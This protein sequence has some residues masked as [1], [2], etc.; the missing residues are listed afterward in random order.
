MPGL[1]E[2]LRRERERQGL[3]VSAIAA[4]TRIPAR[5]IEAIE[6]GDLNQLP[7]NFFA[8][9]FVR[10]YA[11]ALAIP[12]PDIETELDRWLSEV[13][14]AETPDLSPRTLD[15]TLPPVTHVV[16]GGR[17][18]RS[19]LLGAVLTLA[20][21]IAICAVVYSLWL[22]RRTGAPVLPSPESSA[23]PPGVIEPAGEPALAPD[24]AGVESPGPLTAEAPAPSPAAAATVLPPSEGPLWFE[25]SAREETWVRVRSRDETL[26][27]GV[28]QPG[29]SRR[30]SGL[31]V[32]TMRVG[33]A[34]GLELS[35]NGG[36]AAAVGPRGQIRIVSL[37][38]ENTDIAP[39][40]RSNPA[41]G[42]SGAGSEAN[43]DDGIGD[44]QS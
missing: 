40:P 23:A 19:R 6:S 39:P 4:E 8:R 42:L 13:A 21:V 30:F 27:V 44:P 25:I 34:G 1:G 33:N 38:P 17:R 3:E 35:V 26:F 18:P 37:S 7:G 24:D 29:D 22:Q 12:M 15:A 43:P 36:P 2:T 41:G 31:E 20:G 16:E 5:Y 10:Q 9:S 11:H 28:L 14:P 32:A